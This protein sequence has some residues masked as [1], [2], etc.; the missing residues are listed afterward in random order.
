MDR[1]DV[2]SIFHLG[3]ACRVNNID[4]GLCHCEQKCVYIFIS[5]STSREKSWPSFSDIL[6]IPGAQV[7]V[8]ARNHLDRGTEGVARGDRTR[9]Q[10]HR[11]CCV[12]ACPLSQN[13]YSLLYHQEQGK[14][15]VM[16]CGDE[17]N[18]T[19]A[20]NRTA[21]YFQFVLG[22]MSCWLQVWSWN[23]MICP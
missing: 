8:E 12:A 1:D 9:C 20:I 4:P 17:V 6:S 7:R 22:I 10:P 13:G 21:E 23:S 5:T 3:A 19:L 11:A 16:L 2:S 14:G 15:H 18:L